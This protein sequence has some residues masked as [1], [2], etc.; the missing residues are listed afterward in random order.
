MKKLSFVIAVWMG[1]VLLSACKPAASAASGEQTS[2]SLAAMDAAVQSITFPAATEGKTE[3]NTAGYSISPFDIT[4][5]LPEGWSVGKAVL[6]E[7]AIDNRAIVASL[8]STLY[9]CDASGGKV[10]VIGYG[11]YEPYEGDSDTPAVV[12]SAIGLGNDNHFDVR[13]NYCVVEN[14]EV[15]ETATAPVYSQDSAAD[16]RES[17]KGILSYNRDKLVYIAMIF[18]SNA[19]SEEQQTDLAKSVT[20]LP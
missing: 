3:Y 18:D 20:F 8:Y 2:S 7:D 5:S 14:T 9:I 17:G 13:E 15:G 12:Y 10:G 4:F 16:A 6:P 1:F 11:V 19:L